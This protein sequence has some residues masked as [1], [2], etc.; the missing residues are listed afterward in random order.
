MSIDNQKQSPYTS[1]IE[2]QY[3]INIDGFIRAEAARAAALEVIANFAKADFG[4]A[5]KGK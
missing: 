2:K 3:L 4:K 5:T 1:A